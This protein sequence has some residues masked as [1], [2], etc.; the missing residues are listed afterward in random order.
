MRRHWQSSYHSIHSSVGTKNCISLKV[1]RND[2]R[3]AN[4]T[5]PPVLRSMFTLT[6]LTAAMGRDGGAKDRQARGRSER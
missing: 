4:V 3:T 5:D 2:G 1:L 6:N